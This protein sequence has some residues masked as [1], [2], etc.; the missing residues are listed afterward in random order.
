MKKV[1]FCLSMVAMLMTACSKDEEENNDSPQ[2]GNVELPPLPNPNDVCSAMDDLE[3]M[4]FCYEKFD[5][6]KDGAVSR[7]EADAVKEMDIRTEHDKCKS[8]K[9]IGYF[10]NLEILNCKGQEELK[11]VDLSFSLK[12]KYINF[13]YCH[14]LKDIILPENLQTIGKECFGSSELVIITLPKNLKTIEA[15]AFYMC[16]NL[17]TVYCKASVPPTYNGGGWHENDDWDLQ[18]STWD[19]LFSDASISKIYVPKAAVGAYK[20]AKGWRKYASKIEGY[21]F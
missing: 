18:D 1:L 5:I 15:Q 12:L 14:E 7:T 2:N 9:G 20:Q 11:E 8:L 3:F 6:N 4:A 10:T 17:T 19:A 21:N 13:N 16:D